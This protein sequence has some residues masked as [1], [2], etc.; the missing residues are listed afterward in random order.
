MLIQLKSFNLLVWQLYATSL[1]L[2]L[3]RSVSNSTETFYT[4]TCTKGVR[5]VCYVVLCVSVL[6]TTYNTLSAYAPRT[7]RPFKQ[8]NGCVPQ[9]EMFVDAGKLCRY[10]LICQNISLANSAIDLIHHLSSARHS[11][12]E[13]NEISGKYLTLCWKETIWRKSMSNFCFNSKRKTFI[14]VIQINHITPAKH[15]SKL[16]PFI[17]IQK[18]KLFG[19]RFAAANLDERFFPT[20]LCEFTPYL[21]Q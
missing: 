15:E 21:L 20:L 13:Q 8:T 3:L 19:K 14:K 11:C 1:S 2:P 18:E 17:C 10:L 4:L 9:F 7:C 16:V 12:T 5:K 6:C